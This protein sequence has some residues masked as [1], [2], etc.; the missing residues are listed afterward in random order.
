MWVSGWSTCPVS[1]SR[2]WR[3]IW[4]SSMTVWRCTTPATAGRRWRRPTASSALPNPSSGHCLSAAPSAAHLHTLPHPSISD[5]K[6]L[7]LS[8]KQHETVLQRLSRA[9]LFSSCLVSIG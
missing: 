8:W 9:S 1:R 4:T 5:E 3:R 7:P 6:K 2:R